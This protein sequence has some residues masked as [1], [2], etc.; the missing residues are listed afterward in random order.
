MRVLNI[1]RSEADETVKKLM[2]AFGGEQS[3]IVPLYEGD[4]DWS[5]LVDDIFAHDKVI[6]WW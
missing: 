5:K 6:C 2:Q 3:T 4:V 1:L